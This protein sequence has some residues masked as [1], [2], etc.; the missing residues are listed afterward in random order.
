MPNLAAFLQIKAVTEGGGGGASAV[1]RPGGIPA[2][3]TLL[4]LPFALFLFK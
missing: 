2:V 1:A 4:H 3:F